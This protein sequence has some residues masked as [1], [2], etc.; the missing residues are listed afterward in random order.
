MGNQNLRL[1]LSKTEQ[2]TST[3]PSPSLGYE[4]II[5]HTTP[6]NETQLYQT[7]PTAAQQPKPKPTQ[8]S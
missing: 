7:Q 5:L 8:L 4:S 3:N 1:Q 6:S 2:C